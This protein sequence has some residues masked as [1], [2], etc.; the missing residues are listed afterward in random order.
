MTRW[1]RIAAILLL[2]R[3]AAWASGDMPPNTSSSTNDPYNGPENHVG[4]YYHFKHHGTRDERLYY[5][6]QNEERIHFLKQKIQM[7]AQHE[8]HL[9]ELELEYIEKGGSPLAM[10]QMRH[11]VAKDQALMQK[12]VHEV[13][14]RQRIERS[15]RH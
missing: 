12:M 1:T 13:H 6:A 10:H 5:L 7:L 9:K 15:L 3:Y 8:A 4:R 11:Q 14:Q 2:S